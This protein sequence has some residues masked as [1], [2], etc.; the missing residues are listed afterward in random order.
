MRDDERPGY[1]PVAAQDAIS[2]FSAVNSYGSGCH[3]MGATATSPEVRVATQGQ[4]AVVMY[5][6]HSDGKVLFLVIIAVSKGGDTHQPPVALCVLK[7]CVVIDIIS[8]PGGLEE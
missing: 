5:H 7:D 2:A 1:S 3:E 4:P 8:I 6:A